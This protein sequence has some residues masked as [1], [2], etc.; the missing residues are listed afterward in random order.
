MVKN[1]TAHGRRKSQEGQ[2]FPVVGIGSSLS[3][4]IGKTSTYLTEKEA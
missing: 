3:S 1:K 2:V 4:E